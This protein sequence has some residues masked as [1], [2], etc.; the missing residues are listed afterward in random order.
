MQDN[1]MNFERPETLY[2]GEDNGKKWQ[3]SRR[4]PFSIL[5]SKTLPSL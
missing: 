4:N 3:D 2:S 5:C 1:Y